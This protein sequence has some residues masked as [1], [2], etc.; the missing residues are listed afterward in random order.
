M[1]FGV[2]VTPTA[3]ITIINYK[4]EPFLQQILS[5]RV[6]GMSHMTKGTTNE[7]HVHTFLQSK[8]SKILPVLKRLF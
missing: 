4:K 1:R 7:G 2:L 6:P 3:M 5:Y 8:A